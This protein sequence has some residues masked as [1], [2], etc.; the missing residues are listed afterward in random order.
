MF[1]EIL[2]QFNAHDTFAFIYNNT[3]FAHNAA[4]ELLGN[5]GVV[6]LGLAIILYVQIIIRYVKY[7]KVDKHFAIFGLA[8]ITF[9]SIYSL[10]ESG[11]FIFA[12]SFD[13]LVLSFIIVT[14]IMRIYP[15]KQ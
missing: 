3:S 7:I 8:L 1:G 11:S 15:Y 4:L 12:S 9:A 13:Y 14:P 2:Y 6:M 5:G 10:F